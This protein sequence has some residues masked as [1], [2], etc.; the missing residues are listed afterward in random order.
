[1]LPLIPQ[2]QSVED[3]PVF[4]EIPQSIL[5]KIPDTLKSPAIKGFPAYGGFSASASF[6]LHLEDGRRVF[7][8][9]NHPGEM[10]HGAESLRQEISAYQSIPVLKNISPAFLGDVSDGDE[11][12][13]M[14]GLWEY[15]DDATV[16]PDIERIIGALIECHRPL[17]KILDL[18]P[19]LEKSYIS[20]FFSD[21]KKWRRILSESVIQKKFSHMFESADSA[22]G[23]VK[24]NAPRL[25]DLQ[26]KAQSMNSASGLLHGDLRLDNFLFTADK[27]FIIDWPNACYGPVLFDLVFLFANME[28]LGYGRTE[29]FLQLYMQKSG[30][31]FSTEDVAIMLTAISGY[32]AD[33][34]YRDVPPRLPRLRWMQKSMLLALLNTLTRLGV[35]DSLPIMRGAAKKPADIV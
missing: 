21:E 17:P 27:T 10:A 9:G 32:F 26:S 23:W 15:V 28:S 33:Q 29:N 18:K 3:K 12:G 14:L 1:M 5:N 35:V 20:F 19:A 22:E 31:V 7:A 4:D 16:A 25:C 34:A 24:K 2:P 6:I 30:V 13:W 8:K 11:D